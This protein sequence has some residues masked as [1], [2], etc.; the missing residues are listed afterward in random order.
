MKRK[1]EIKELYNMARQMKYYEFENWIAKE[2]FNQPGTVDTSELTDKLF[3]DDV[4]K[5]SY[6]L[7]DTPIIRTGNFIKGYCGIC[8]K[9]IK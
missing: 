3:L 9:D 8:G 5:T 6:C 7:C 2:L 1:I 4:V